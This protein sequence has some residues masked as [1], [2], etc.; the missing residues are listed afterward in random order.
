MTRHQ[1]KRGGRGSG[2]LWMDT[3]EGE[4]GELLGEEESK[5][6]MQEKEKDKYDVRR[7]YTLEDGDEVEV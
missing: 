3:Q 6:K 1:Q 2:Q 5:D 4:E 7:S